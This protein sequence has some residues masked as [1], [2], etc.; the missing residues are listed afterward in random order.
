MHASARRVLAMC[1]LWSSPAD[2]EGGRRGQTETTPKRGDPM[3]VDL[4]AGQRPGFDRRVRSSKRK[5][6]PRQYAG[7]T[8][9]RSEVWVKE[10]SRCWR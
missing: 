4:Q 1:T 9:R 2:A 10:R 8:T 5:P 6:Q 3:R 7:S